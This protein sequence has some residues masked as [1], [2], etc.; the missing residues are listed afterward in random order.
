MLARL[1]FSLLDDKE[2]IKEI[3][4]ESLDKKELIGDTLN[5]YKYTSLIFLSFED[6]DNALFEIEEAEKL[7]PTEIYVHQHKLYVLRH[8]SEKYLDKMLETIKILISLYN[9]NELKK[10][11]YLNYKSSVLKELGD[12]DNS[13]KAINEAINL[14]PYCEYFIARAFIYFRY[15]HQ[16][17]LNDEE[18][19]KLEQKIMQ[20]I[21]TAMKDANCEAK[22]YIHFKI[23]ALMYFDKDEQACEEIKE[24]LN[25]GEKLP[26]DQYEIDAFCDGVPTDKKTLEMNFEF[27]PSSYNERFKETVIDDDLKL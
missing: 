9:D 7:Y 13:L 17:E 16:K 15:I 3:L 23:M 2:P 18:H 10:A 24:I 19:I 25:R 4:H 22:D 8:A 21:E 26:W 6:I 5:Y 14:D 11:Y 20:D 12:L 1:N 27:N